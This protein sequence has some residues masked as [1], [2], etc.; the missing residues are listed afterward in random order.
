MEWIELHN[1]M[2]VDVNLSGWSLQDAVDFTFPAGTILE[3]RA[4]SCRGSRPG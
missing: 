1:Q 3:A 2:S 4:V